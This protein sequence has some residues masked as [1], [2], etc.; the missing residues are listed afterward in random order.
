LSRIALS[1]AS[2]SWDGLLANT[3]TSTMILHGDGVDVN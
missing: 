3:E 1:K 2:P